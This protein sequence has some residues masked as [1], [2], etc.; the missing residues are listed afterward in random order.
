VESRKKESRKLKNE[1][2]KK[3]ESGKYTVGKKKVDR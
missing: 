1:G 2:K 3:S